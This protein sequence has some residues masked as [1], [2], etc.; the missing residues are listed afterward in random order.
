M[1]RQDI[2]SADVANATTPGYKSDRVSQREFG[3]LM[4]TDLA[5]GSQV[6]TIGAG[7][8]IEQQVTNLS[9]SDVR[10]TGEPLDLAIVGEGY[11]AIQTDQGVRYTRNGQFQANAKGQLSDAQGNLVLGPRNQPVRVGAD[12]TVA[13][14]AVGLF[15]VPNAAKVGD[16]YFT[17]GA[18][19]NAGGEIRTSALETS[20]LDAARS[21]VNM[22]ASLRAIE[23]GQKAL[24]TIDESLGKANQVGSLR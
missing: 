17:G 22:M 8:R 10:D 13:A 18:T 1:A 6:A 3:K 23:A 15:A 5:T 20:G 12:G 2:L 4:V 24:T 21:V 19:G 14:N 9:P 11:F 7:A 16:N